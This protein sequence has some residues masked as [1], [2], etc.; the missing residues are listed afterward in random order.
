MEWRGVTFGVGTK[1]DRQ[2]PKQTYLSTIQCDQRLV[3][4]HN[5]LLSGS[6]TA[7]WLVFSDKLSK[8]ISKTRLAWKGPLCETLDV[9]VCRFSPANSADPMALSNW[10]YSFRVPFLSADLQLCGST[11]VTDL[12]KIEGETQ[13]SLPYTGGKKGSGFSLQMWKPQWESVL[14]II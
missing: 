2:F 12:K 9:D 6:V 10:L 7:Q 5:F 13:C 4:C 11:P 3:A 1:Y 14:I 8:F